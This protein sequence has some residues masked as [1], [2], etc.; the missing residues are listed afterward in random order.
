MIYADDLGRRLTVS[1]I[2]FQSQR[3]GLRI[4]IRICKLSDVT[5]MRSDVIP[6]NVLLNLLSAW[7][8]Q[9]FANVLTLCSL[10]FCTIRIKRI[11]VKIYRTL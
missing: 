11:D 9:A 3:Q 6:N 5:A 8:L 10:T 2:T 7:K 4:A 1:T